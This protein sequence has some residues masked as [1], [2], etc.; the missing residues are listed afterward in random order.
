MSLD[1]ATWGEIARLWRESDEPLGSIA[2][3]FAIT[4]QSISAMARRQAW[5]ARSR[6]SQAASTHQGTHKQ[7]E[8]RAAGKSRRSR[9]AR[10][11]AGQKHAARTKGTASGSSRTAHGSSGGEGRRA[12]ERGG[13]VD[14][15]HQLSERHAPRS[16]M[17][18]RLFKA[19]DTKLSA[20]EDRIACGED[21]TPADSERTTRA[22][23]TL[24]RS[25]EKLTEY[26]AKLSKTAG[27]RH[28]KRAGAQD[29]PER[30]REELARRIQRLLDRR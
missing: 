1:E 9:K 27:R 2:R 17:V 8:A 6:R 18:E 5:P 12:A 16:S 25:L 28:G 26:E 23:N 7:S 20:I 11:Q 10:K 30:R 19:M 22:I 3:R 15:R 29:D 4:H 14:E 21:A 24:V 13:V